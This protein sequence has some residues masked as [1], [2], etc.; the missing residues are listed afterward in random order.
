MCTEMDISPPYDI[1]WVIRLIICLKF[2]THQNTPSNNSEI[3]FKHIL[4]KSPYLSA[5]FYITLK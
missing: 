2:K 1:Y 4:R 5:N 3:K